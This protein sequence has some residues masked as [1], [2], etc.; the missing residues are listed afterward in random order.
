MRRSTAF[1]VF[2]LVFCSTVW[3]AE[4]PV[5]VS[6]GSS[7]GSLIGDSCPTFSWGIV[8]QAESYELV[9]YQVEKDNEDT[10]PV[11]RQSFPGSVHGWTPSLDRCLERGGQYAWSVRAVRSKASSEWS[12]PSLF[13]VS[14]GPS[15][16][17]FEEAL[18]V[19]RQ[20]LAEEAT[21]SVGVSAAGVEEPLGGA[22]AMLV[23]ALVRRPDTGPSLLG[24]VGDPAL[25]VNGSPVVTVATLAGSVVVRESGLSSG[26]QTVSCVAGERVV[27]GGAKTSAPAAFSIN[28]P[29]ET[30][31]TPSGWSAQANDNAPVNALVLCASP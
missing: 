15:E 29:T 24:V 5:A 4:G 2:L 23:A 27:G 21:G 12:A 19:V 7:T 26:L 30:T 20:Y 9:I 31:G 6:P 8:E 10:E 1:T 22:S 3:G 14:S 28:G 18:Q 11:L 17:E 16:S 13:Q 25:Q